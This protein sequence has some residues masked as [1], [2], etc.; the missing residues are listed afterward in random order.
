VY[1]LHSSHWQ[2][3]KKLLRAGLWR[4]SKKQRLAQIKKLI[5]DEHYE[6][7]LE[8]L[9]L[10]L[11]ADKSNYALHVL[12]GIAHCRLGN[13]DKSAN[14]YCRAAQLRQDMLPAWKGLVELFELDS[15]TSGSSSSSS[16]SSS[17]RH[18]LCCNASKR[19]ASFDALELCSIGDYDSDN[20]NKCAYVCSLD[21]LYRCLVDTDKPVAAQIRNLLKLGD[22]RLSLVL[23]LFN[24]ENDNDGDTESCKRLALATFDCYEQYLS[25]I[26]GRD[27]CDDDDVHRRLLRLCLCFSS[28][29]D[30]EWVERTERVCRRAMALQCDDSAD[31]NHALLDI[32]WL[33]RGNADDAV[34]LA[35]ATLSSQPMD[36]AAAELLLLLDEADQ[37]YVTLDDGARARLSRRLAF[38]WPQRGLGWTRVAEQLGDEPLL[39]AS[40]KSA[41]LSVAGWAALVEL[42]MRE[43]R[44]QA[45]ESAARQ[46]LAAADA[47]QGAAP[48][49]VELT[50]DVLRRRIESALAICLSHGAAESRSRA[51]LL[52]DKLL[53]GGDCTQ[54]LHAYGGMLLDGERDVD[55]A[56]AVYERALMA[57]SRDDEALS[58]LGKMH[59]DAG[60]LDEAR[61]LLTR[62]AEAA[63]ERG[64]HRERLAQCYWALGGEW[65]SDRRHLHRTL[66]LAAKAAPTHTVNFR[67]LGEY[68]RLVAADAK[69]ARRCYEK[70][71]ALDC[72]DAVAGVALADLYLDDGLEARAIALY[73]EASVRSARAHWAWRRLG[74]HH[75]AGAQSAANRGD[76]AALS[77]RALHCFQTA[78]RVDARDALCWQSLAESYRCLGKYMASIKAFERALA[79]DASLHYC[80]YRL[81]GVRLLLGELDDAVAGF[82]L[83]LAGH[84]DN[85]PAR[86]GLGRALLALARRQSSQGFAERSRDTLDE[87]TRVL[88]DGG[89]DEVTAASLVDDT[90]RVLLGDVL[91]ARGSCSAALDAYRS[92]RALPVDRH[93]VALALFALGDRAAA[94][95]EL[96]R[97][98]AEWRHDALA[99]QPSL[100]DLWCALGVVEQQP[101]RKQ[102]ALL[103]AIRLAPDVQ[104][105]R[106]WANLGALYLREHWRQPQPDAE[107]S[108]L[109]V[110]AAERAFQ[111][112]Q[113]RAPD[114]AA[115]WIGQALCSLER[116]DSATAA[117]AFQQALDVLVCPQALVG[118]ALTSFRLG[119][120][121]SAR[122]ACERLA[123]DSAVPAPRRAWALNLLGA[124]EVR[125]ARL[126]DAQRAF[127]SALELARSAADE[128]CALRV[129]R[130]R[131]QAQLTST[132]RLESAR[133][134]GDAARERRALLA[135]A[136]DDAAAARGYLDE[137]VAL[138]L[139]DSDADALHA[140]CALATRVGAADLAS[141]IL[142]QLSPQ[143][144]GSRYFELQCDLLGDGEAIEQRRVVL[145][146]GLRAF[147]D[148]GALWQRHFELADGERAIGA[149]ELLYRVSR[150]HG[151]AAGA[152]L[153][154]G[155]SSRRA[156]VE[157]C[158]RFGIMAHVDPDSGDAWLLLGRACYT[159]ARHS[160]ARRDWA[161][162]L[163]ALQSVPQSA[164]DALSARKQQLHCGALADC[165]HALGRAKQALLAIRAAQSAHSR[166][167]PI[168]LV[169]LARCLAASEA[170]RD[171][172]IEFLR[173]AIANSQGDEATLFAASLELATCH[174]HA[175]DA[176]AV[177]ASL[178]QAIDVAPTSRHRAAA[179]LEL[180]IA[181]HE[182]GERRD[183]AA[184]AKSLAAQHLSKE[185][186][187]IVHR[188]QRVK[189]K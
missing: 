51:R 112:A 122:F 34:Q 110:D 29:D 40:L 7:A 15:N 100:H 11:C 76:A 3:R 140:A 63:P 66:L 109:L 53:G 87:A 27:D 36:C 186:R 119:A 105:A 24:D 69:N 107:G 148:A 14:A 101:A 163:A 33:R 120:M 181:L 60:R 113:A 132:A 54:L 141:R 159:L 117:A 170:K 70:A 20:D 187:A 58:Q 131:H 68:Y 175:A 164:V 137:C 31:F 10:A 64:V 138:A 150:R 37:G 165:L 182:Q 178:E 135:C 95:D 104:S 108:T 65:R 4:M 77:E 174:G 162:A 8:E 25:E 168:L 6:E 28:S 78:L 67:L 136:R 156:L 188:L 128:Q 142:A 160:R 48:P 143:S 93:R 91:A 173:R 61:E 38:V 114:G 103:R 121:E 152:L 79:L 5:G 149:P 146:R 39:R 59:F 171:H 41:K 83:L 19:F 184:I 102:H 50:F 32:V 43:A 74:V 44:I 90:R 86:L 118:S 89:S 55:G 96:Q 82:R 116:A 49:G 71:L 16:S 75:L 133:A 189:R 85:A 155:A 97:A 183:A 2:R 127:E 88:D 167:A 62:A 30:G 166:D 57:D 172:A 84:A 45:C 1:T 12:R 56:R 115:A 99:Q 73:R 18:S 179:Q 46:A 157:A 81:A 145:R 147:P 185:S 47:R 124:V 80:R 177:R 98:I 42:R 72:T 21:R 26:D 13:Y 17:S 52:F 123:S 94:S 134:A 35:W 111:M 153:L 169:A 129:E 92:M 126:D 106:A 161:A 144:I 176:E 22:A 180:A 151:R 23:H 125:S 154:V 158:R 9:K 130:N 139:R